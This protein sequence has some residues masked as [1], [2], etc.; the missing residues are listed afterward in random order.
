M[1]L[2]IKVSITQ[3]DAV[4]TIAHMSYATRQRVAGPGK[5]EE[6]ER[7]QSNPPVLPLSSAKRSQEYI[8]VDN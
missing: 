2:A 1:A 5:K 3:N 8:S 6:E 7:Q 4:V